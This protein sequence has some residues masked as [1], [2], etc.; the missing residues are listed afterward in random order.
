MPMFI[1]TVRRFSLFGRSKFKPEI[2]VFQARTANLA[3]YPPKKREA[4]DPRYR[5]PLSQLDSPSERGGK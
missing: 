1:E 2:F 4:G 5:L 3:L